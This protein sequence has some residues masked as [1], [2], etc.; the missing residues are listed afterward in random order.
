VRLDD[1]ELI[2]REYATEDGLRTRAQVHQGIAGT[3]AWEIVVAAV[4]EGMPRRVLEVGCGWGDLAVRLQDELGA[5]VVAVD[6]S[7]RMVELA[8]DRGVD[9]R[10]ADVHDLPF[11]DSEFDCVTANWMLYHVAD[12]D[13]GV[14][15]LA[16][17]LQPGGRLVAATNG[18][19]HLTEL[20]SLVGRDRADEPIRFF[21]ETGEPF[22]R[23]YFDH[24]ERHDV[25]STVT[26]ADSAAVRDYISSL[27]AQ[28][29]RAA[30][31]PELDTPLVAT[32]RNSVFVARRA[33]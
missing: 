4:A 17:V 13:R 26:F 19:T 12:L 6:I 25:E 9:A 3:E 32:R 22:L 7:P 10:V 20:W 14:S 21:A 30:L 18:L 33:G 31:V 15:E 2:R 23:R 28:R 16:R 8:R 27:V 5:E 11:A 24:V 29:D 1:P